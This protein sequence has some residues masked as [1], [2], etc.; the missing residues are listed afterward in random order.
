M[1]LHPDF[2]ARIYNLSI[3]A[4]DDQLSYLMN[5]EKDSFFGAFI[6]AQKLFPMCTVDLVP[7][8]L[9][10]RSDFDITRDIELTWELQKLATDPIYKTKQILDT[11]R[12]EDLALIIIKYSFFADINIAE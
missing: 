8:A 6:C 11:L 9:R 3:N 7:S 2:A 5:E 1:P 10:T 12:D 4:L